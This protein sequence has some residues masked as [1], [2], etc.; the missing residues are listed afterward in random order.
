M[1]GPGFDRAVRLGSEEAITFVHLSLQEFVA[2]EYLAELPGADLESWITIHRREDSWADVIALA[3]GIGAAGRIIRALLALDDPSNANSNEVIL[4]AAALLEIKNPDPSLVS[5]VVQD[6][7][8][9][10]IPR[11]R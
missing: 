6:S 9:D 8:V 11:F 7:E 10:S 1:G 2:A 5:E 3:C 4:A